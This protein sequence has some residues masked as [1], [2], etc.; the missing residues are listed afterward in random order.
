LLEGT[1][2]EPR[3]VDVVATCAE[4]GTVSA[5][6]G[7]P[8][9]SR[10]QPTQIFTPFPNDKGDLLAAILVWEAGLDEEG[11]R[12]KTNAVPD[13]NKA[14]TARVQ[15]EKC[16]LLTTIGAMVTCVNGL[17]ATIRVLRTLTGIFALSSSSNLLCS[18]YGYCHSTYVGNYSA[19]APCS[20]CFFSAATIKA[21]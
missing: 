11:A 20:H 8:V 4:S 5:R 9:S 10:L 2:L 12:G 21:I 7:Y 15:V 6:E 3:I 17:V 18:N 16:R 13:A 19:Q 1:E 14:H